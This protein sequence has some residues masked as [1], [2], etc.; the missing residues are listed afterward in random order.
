[1][2]R[3]CRLSNFRLDVE[4]DLRYYRFWLDNR[5]QPLVP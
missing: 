4:A 3:L 2:G 5:R 1:M